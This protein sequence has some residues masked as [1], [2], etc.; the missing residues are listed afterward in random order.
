M[1]HISEIDDVIGS[2]RNHPSHRLPCEEEFFHQFPQTPRPITYDEL[3]RL[4]CG[5]TSKP[6]RKFFD[7][8]QH[9]D[10]NCSIDV[11]AY[12]L[13][14]HGARRDWG[15][16]IIDAGVDYLAKRILELNQEQNIPSQ[17]Y[18][19][20]T[21]PDAEY[22]AKHKLLLHELGHH[23]TE[24]VH[25]L[26]EL[27]PNNS[28]QYSYSSTRRPGTRGQMLRENEESV[29]NWNVKKHKHDFEIRA[30]NNYDVINDFMLSQPSGYKNFEQITGQNFL[31]KI[32]DVRLTGG[33]AHQMPQQI[34][35]DL[36]NE[37]ARHSKLSRVRPRSIH[38]PKI[39]FVVPIYL[40]QTGKTFQQGELDPKIREELKFLR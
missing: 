23:A 5:D 29:C 36:E 18:Y 15:I 27:Y 20:L 8:S 32:L 4:Y 26:L 28:I 38:E 16:Y 22:L 1:M 2:S 35:A 21:Q 13:P 14:F 39:G 37:F 40:I 25:S 34:R 19:P 12:Y 6:F 31:E 10:M 33:L 30:L 24:I 7:H 3:M 11:L 17:E 9:D